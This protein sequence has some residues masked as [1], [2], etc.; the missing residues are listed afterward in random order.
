MLCLSCVR[1]CDPKGPFILF[2]SD[3]FKLSICQIT[4]HSPVCCIGHFTH[5]FKKKSLH[6]E[7]KVS[8]I[9]FIIFMRKLIHVINFMNSLLTPHSFFIYS[10]KKKKKITWLFWIIDRNYQ[11]CTLSEKSFDMKNVKCFLS[12]LYLFFISFSIIL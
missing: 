2:Q 7:K 9:I 3:T 5:L 6:Q 4:Q 10:L 8:L 11:L 12:C 1:T